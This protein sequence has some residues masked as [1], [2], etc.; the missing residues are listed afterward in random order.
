[1][2]SKRGGAT[3][4][5][6]TNSSATRIDRPIADGSELNS[7]VQTP[8]E[9][10]ATAAWV[11]LSIALNARPAAGR[12][13]SDVEEIWRRQDSAHR[14]RVGQADGDLP[15]RVAGQPLQAGQPLAKRRVVCRRRHGN[16]A[17]RPAAISAH[18]HAHE[19]ILRGDLRK[20]K[21]QHRVQ[22]R[23]RRDRDR[24][25]DRQA[26]DDPGRV[27]ACVEQRTAAVAQ[28]LTE[29]VRPGEREPARDGHACH[30]ACL[31]NRLQSNP[32]FDARRLNAEL[33]LGM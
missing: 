7:R 29:R 4:T 3:P 30:S 1:M 18:G 21:D 22:E 23:Q 12:T 25:P 14:S 9:I 17:V 19:A 10:T 33:V 11:S 6:W 24:H 16:P 20:R 26:S 2:P 8:C 28:I 13:P 32:R 5:I 15:L 31:G 27:G